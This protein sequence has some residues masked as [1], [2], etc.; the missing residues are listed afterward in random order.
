MRWLWLS[1]NV[2]VLSCATA[3]KAVEA[4][5]EASGKTLY[6]RLGGKPA[7]EAVIDE[8]LAQVAADERVNASFAGSHLPRLRRRLIELVCSASGGGCSYSGRDMKSVHAGMG[9]T[10]AQFDAVA[11]D[12]VAALDKFKVPAK[13]KTELL[14]VISPM[15][16][17]MVEEP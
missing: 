9:I 6:E 3:P 13:E 8:F 4:R 5:A 12:L 14:S 16:A 7:I 10:S 2:L 11:A 17:V 15:R 1:A